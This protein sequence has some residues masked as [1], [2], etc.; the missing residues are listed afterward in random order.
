MTKQAFTL[1]ET[2]IVIAIT[3]MMM[4]A[5]AVLYINF[6]LLYTYQQTFVATTRAAGS[7][8]NAIGA[9][10]LPADQ[11]LASHAFASGT[12][13]S[14]ATALVLELPTIDSSG[15][16]VV[17]KYDYIALYLTGTDL[18]RKIEADATSSRTSSTK[19]VAT[20]VNSLT[21]TYDNADFTKV[22]KVDTDVITQLNAR[23]GP[24]QTHLHQQFYLR[25]I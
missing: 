7:A 18:Y 20:L 10:T 2:V 5:I 11:V 1:I 15:N 22:T 19:R 16:T 14:G 13:S 24:I 9:V 8:V 12:I 21:F 17:G 6:N 4:L 3:T 23:Q 25:N